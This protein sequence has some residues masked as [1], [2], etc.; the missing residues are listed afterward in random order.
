MKNNPIL[1]IGLAAAIIFFEGIIMAK[2]KQVQ[3]PPP[4]TKGTIS[5]EEA[6]QKRRSQ[7]IF[8]KRELSLV[9]IGQLAWAGQGVTDQ[10]WV[11]NSLRTAPSAGALYPLEIY[12]LTKDGLFH[13]LPDGHK[14]DAVA[15]KDLRKELAVAALGQ[16]AI[17]EA[18]MVMVICAVYERVTAK[19]SARGI[20]YTHLEAGHAAQ[21]ILLQAVALGLGAVPIGA[22]MPD[23][24]QKVLQAPKE[25]VPLYIIPVGYAE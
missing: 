16:N 1:S 2:E 22:F 3:L 24:V 7:R 5:V 12:I 6:L 20:T 17:K 15:A 14:M 23:D 11:R 25:Q 21:N 18:P 8:T 10:R 13:Y 19:Y 9:E 4:S